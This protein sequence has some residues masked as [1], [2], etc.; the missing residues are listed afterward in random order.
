MTT[1]LPEA[2]LLP[3]R[4]FSRKAFLKGGGALV[5]GVS[6]AGTV[7]SGTARAAGS[8]FAS[9][10]SPS[11]DQV[12]SFVAVHADNTASILTGRVE[13]GQ[14]SATGL[15]LVAAE[16]LGMDVSQLKFVRHDTNVT[17]NTG[18]TA[19]SSSIRTGGL[20][21][22]SAA[23]TARQA[24]L[25]MAASR[26]GVPISSLSVNKGVVSGS[27][28]SVSY[29]QLIGGGLFNVSMASPQLLPGV[30][31]AKPVSSYTLVGIV[32]LPR[33]DIPA[34]V[35]GTYTYVQNLRVPGMLHG[36]IVRPRGQG[37]YGAGTADTIV[38]VDESSISHI[39]GARVVRRNN[40][41]GVVAAKE[42]D[43]IQAAV[44]LKVT[45][46]EPPP[47]SGSGDLWQQMRAFDSAGQAPASIQA[48]TGDVVAALASAAHTVTQTYKYHY[49]SHVSIGPSCA[50]AD[51]TP[52]GALVMA[53]T[54]DAYAVRSKLQPLLNLPQNLI[55][56]VYWEGSGSY[57]NAPARYDT[58][59]AA[60]VMSQLAGTPVRLQFMRWDEDG[61]D[62]YGPA[63]MVDM[64]GGIDAKGN[65]VAL[66]YTGFQIPAMS[67]DPT[68]QHVGFPLDPPGL[69]RADTTNS[70]TQYIIP[71]RR[72]TAKSL[73]L[74][75]NYFKT[76]TLRAPGAP[77]ACFASEQLI[78]ELAHA[79]N[80]DPYQFRLQNITTAQVNDGYNQWRDAL[81][82]VAK[83]ANWQ[84]KVAA[85]NLSDATIVTGRGIALGGYANSQAAVVADI[86]VNKKTGKIVCT[87]AYCA[88]VAGLTV[89]LGGV[90][91]QQE[92]NLVMATSRALVEEVPFNTH[93]STGLDWVSY[94]ILRFKDSPTVTTTIVQR[95]DLAPTG[96]GE[97]PE[98][99]TPAAIANAFFDATGVRIRT[100]PLTPARVRATLKAAGLV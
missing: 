47:I 51:V 97:P 37:A 50:V 59:L 71:N 57:G 41:L 40:F 30:A 18:I 44:Q 45:W 55:R 76:H 78:D 29:G 92:G 74:L 38:S 33:I 99:P 69:G 16:E 83:L 35:T 81:T 24:L 32:D 62:N 28:R 9:N 96:S 58:S 15:L 93:R 2:T 3:R 21:V 39:P 87:H 49:Q 27:G 20:W 36:R 10:G 75:N 6:L 63:T 14:G 84:P 4:E 53:N 56:V 7:G 85:S 91:N 52:N 82:A 43:A 90:S 72:V 95:T 98:A 64:R 31:P 68:T 8:P 65:I 60:A 26:L 80:I 1:L 42:W 25:T 67:T 23:A 73:P 34:K 22:R 5:V 88:Q 12:D 61:W 89:Y 70:G 79:A 17:P 11:L 54:Q 77:Q 100:A 48:D 13:L 94:P 19:G 86:Q 66:D 46:A